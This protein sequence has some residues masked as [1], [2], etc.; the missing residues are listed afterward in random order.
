[1]GVYFDKGSGLWRA[2]VQKGGRRISTTARTAKEAREIE[3]RIRRESDPG[4]EH[5]LEEAIT[6]WLD[7]ESPKLKRKKD[8]ES[9]ARAL[10]PFLSEARISQAPEVWRRY[11]NGNVELTSSSHNRR[12][13]LIKRVCGLASD[14]GWCEPG[15]ASRIN[16]LQENPGRHV[17]LTPAQVQALH[18]A[19]DFQPTKDA[20]L[21]AAYSGLRIGEIMKLDGSTRDGCL[22]LGDTKNGKPRLV[23]I[24]PA[25]RKAVERLPIPCGTRW[26]TRHFDRARE[27]LGHP[28]WHFHDLRH[29]NASWLIQAG[30]DLV[31][32]RDLLGHSSLAVTSRYTHLA[33][34][35]LRE[36]VSKLPAPPVHRKKRAKPAK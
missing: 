31:T 12:G 5:S 20:I 16:L 24:H 33:T 19:T 3:A 4:R 30:A 14:W 34:D 32:V 35:H 28:E 15:L 6:R 26:V 21:I 11:L 18:E 27:R 29:T 8:Y 7:E 2:Q 1:M 25:I 23:P 10:I 17:Y 22:Y 36:A 13:A 9:H